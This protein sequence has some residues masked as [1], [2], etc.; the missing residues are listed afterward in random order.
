[1]IFEDYVRGRIQDLA[2]LRTA[3]QL[4]D[5]IEA[6]KGSRGRDSAHSDAEYMLRAALRIRR[7][8][9]RVAELLKNAH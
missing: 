2:T 4:E 5:A 7:A 1:M 6:L 8:D 3:R 9:D